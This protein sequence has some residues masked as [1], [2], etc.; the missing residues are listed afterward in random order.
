MSLNDEASLEELTK[1]TLRNMRML[2]CELPEVSTLYINFTFFW[3]SMKPEEK[4]E[5]VLSFAT[6]FFRRPL[7]NNPSLPA[8]FFLF[9]ISGLGYLPLIKMSNISW[10]FFKVNFFY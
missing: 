2:W 9:S 3:S 7:G 1:G 10:W 4:V 8:C 5:T 6:F